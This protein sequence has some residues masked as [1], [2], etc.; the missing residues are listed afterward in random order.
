M[1][2]MVIEQAYLGHAKEDGTLVSVP[3]G[4]KVDLRTRLGTLSHLPIRRRSV[5]MIKVLL[6]LTT[7][8]G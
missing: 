1:V 5:T 3:F 8:I 4:K 7:T 6:I 2:M